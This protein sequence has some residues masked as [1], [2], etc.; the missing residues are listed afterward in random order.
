MNTS[1]SIKLKYLSCAP[2]RIV[3]D[4]H[5]M[6]SAN[7]KVVSISILI[8]TSLIKLIRLWASAAYILNYIQKYLQI[9]KAVKDFVKSFKRSFK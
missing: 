3:K 6:T 2:T 8:V 7:H 9:R 4:M 1:I 5:E